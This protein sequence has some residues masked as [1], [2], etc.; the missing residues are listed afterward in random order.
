MNPLPFCWNESETPNQALIKK[1][2]VHLEHSVCPL[3]RTNRLTVETPLTG[4]ESQTQ[5]RVSFA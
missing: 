3:L 2:S 4:I 5:C 1:E